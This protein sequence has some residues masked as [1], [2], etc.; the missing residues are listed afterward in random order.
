MQ[1]KLN[2]PV[3]CLSENLQGRDFVVGD[4]HGCASLL[5]AA[6]NQVNFDETRDRLL[7][8]GDLIDRGPDSYAL[9]SW[10][11]KPWFF[12]CLGNHEEILLKFMASGDHELGSQWSSF[13]G[14]WF[15]RLRP[16]QRIELA[17]KISLNMSYAIECRLQ[18]Q[19]YAV[20]H[21]DFPPDIGWP[22]FKQGIDCK[23]EWQRSCLWDR[24]RGKGLRLDSME[25]IDR[26][27]TGH[28]IVD[29]PRLIG[30]VQMIDTGAYKA[31][32]GDGKLTLAQL[33]GDLHSF[34]LS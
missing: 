25:G 14:S 6:L 21:A 31:Q 34:S 18:Q 22:A 13:G 28:H 15:F 30:N 29:E 3:H 9:L 32:N 26:L 12:S 1:L 27:F 24:D 4:V 5:E 19:L 10:L 17:E 11:G 23:P 33:A 20:M 16:Q 7:S 2:Q 8:V